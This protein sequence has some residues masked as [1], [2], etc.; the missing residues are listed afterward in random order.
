MNARQ[1]FDHDRKKE[2]LLLLGPPPL[3]QRHLPPGLL[4][5]ARRLGPPGVVLSEPRLGVRCV[6]KVDLGDGRLDQRP[7]APVE[8]RHAPEDVHLLEQ[9]LDLGVLVDDSTSAAA[10][11]P[12]LEEAKVGLDVLGYEL[13]AL[14]A[15]RQDAEVAVETAPLGEVVREV[16]GGGRGRRVLVVDKGDGRLL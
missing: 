12:L 15:G 9:L 1:Q 7:D 8:A 14:G 4:P 11:V 2:C 5:L 13:A 6:V 10:G 3:P 16:E